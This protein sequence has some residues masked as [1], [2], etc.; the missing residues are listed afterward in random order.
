[1]NYKLCDNDTLNMG[2]Y[3]KEQD[4]CNSLHVKGKVILKDPINM[5]AVRKGYLL[6]NLHCNCF[7][8]ENFEST[9]YTEYNYDNYTQI[10]G[11]FKISTYNIWGIDRTDEE[12][13]LINIRMPLIAKQILD[14]DIDIIC[15]QEMGLT[16]YNILS[17]LLLNYTIYEQRNN[18]SYDRC[19]DVECAIAMKKHIIPKTIKMIP[20]GG[21]LTYT[22]S[23]M[24][25]EFNNFN[26]YNCYLQA[27]S[28]HS[29]GQ[30]KLYIHY[31]RCRLQLLE[32]IMTQLDKITPSILLGDF[33]INL[34]D[35]IENYPELRGI[36]KIINEYGFI[37]SWILNKDDGYTEN[38]D[39]NIMRWNDKM[40]DKTSRVDAIF[41]RGF[42]ILKSFIIGDKDYIGVDKEYESKYIE[43]F[44]P[45]KIDTLSKLK[46]LNING[47]IKLPI[48]ASDHFGVVLL[49]YI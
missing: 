31:S 11:K 42:T 24:I 41:T 34:N 38:T 3:I 23:L 26:I 43:Y 33:N 1:M 13:Y 30:E 39:I 27:G 32:Y 18:N 29:I 16:S 2:L 7:I 10:N 5:E 48:F 45:N 8:K 12:K 17:K 40:K 20:L 35:T 28:K 19:H 6:D 9:N 22:N 46:R 4:E 14:H 37:D 21:N 36:N 47:K 44:T 15:F 49:C 25:I